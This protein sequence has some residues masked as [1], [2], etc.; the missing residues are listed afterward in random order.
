M[1]FCWKFSDESKTAGGV[2]L[3]ISFLFDVFSVACF[4][5]EEY[6]TAK[7]SFEAGAALDPKTAS[8]KSWITKC[9]AKLRGTNSSFRIR[10][11]RCAPLL[12]GI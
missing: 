11:K 7:T 6:E 9:D 4:Y 10:I 3:I 8:F 5:L 1:H 2:N 12:H